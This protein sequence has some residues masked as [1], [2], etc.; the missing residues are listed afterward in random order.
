[1][2][3]LASGKN[4][5]TFTRCTLP[6]AWPLHV[7]A[8]AMSASYSCGAGAQLP[9]TVR[10]VRPSAPAQTVVASM[11]RTFAW[12]AALA[13]TAHA[14]DRVERARLRPGAAGHNRP[15]RPVVIRRLASAALADLGRIA[16]R[17]VAFSALIVVA[18]EA[19]RALDRVRD[20]CIR[21]H[22]PRRRSSQRLTRGRVPHQPAGSGRP[23]AK[24]WFV[25][26]RSRVAD[27]PTAGDHRGCGNAARDRVSA[28]GY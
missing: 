27:P 8:S 15:D 16:H 1:M 21:V 25:S 2:R 5:T 11:S 18:F 13:A 17:P 28:S 20:R 10:Q 14:S 12:S 7:P 4:V 6:T 24:T 3:R 26:R 22:S 19:R 9:F 23:V